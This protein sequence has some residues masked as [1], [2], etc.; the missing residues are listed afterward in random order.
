MNLRKKLL[1]IFRLFFFVLYNLF[2]IQ[3]IDVE[4]FVDNERYKWLYDFIKEISSISEIY[5][6]STL[7]LGMYEIIP[8]F[9]FK[10]FSTMEIEY[11]IFIVILNVIFLNFLNEYLRSKGISFLLTAIIIFSSFYVFKL[12]FTLHKLKIAI[13]FFFL[14]KKYFKKNVLSTLIIGLLAHYQF[15]ILTISELFSLKEL[16]KRF[17]MILIFIIVLI[18]YFFLIDG[19]LVKI[20]YYFNNLYFTDFFISVVF[21]LSMIYILSKKDLLK[22]FAISISTIFFGNSRINIMIYA[23]VADKAIVH[24][25]VLFSFLVIIPNIWFWL[26]FINNG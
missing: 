24:N 10:T 3:I 4:N 23:Y 15:L 26:N 18:T 17:N 2:F 21:I 6:H 8:I 11:L 14:I 25:K 22:L 9:I 12:C 13:I 1:I 19:F 16:T 7:N 20:F 5:F